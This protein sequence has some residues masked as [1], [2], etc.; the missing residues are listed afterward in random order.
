VI[1]RREHALPFVR[2]QPG[3]CGEA[4]VAFVD[5]DRA[6]RPGRRQQCEPGELVEPPAPPGDAIRKRHQ[7]CGDIFRTVAEHRARRKRGVP[8]PRVQRHGKLLQK[9]GP[10]A[11]VGI[12]ERDKF[13][14][15]RGGVR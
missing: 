14:Y 5:D 4:L 7:K 11:R 12:Q 2:G 8:E 1:E 9:I 10:Q 15:R 6:Y 13:H 3:Q